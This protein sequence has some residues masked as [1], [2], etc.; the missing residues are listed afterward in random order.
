M[1]RIVLFGG[2][3][4]V[5]K[6]AV[7]ARLIPRL[8]ERGM[9]PCVC[10]IDCAACDDASVLAAGGVP[11]VTGVSVDTCPDH[12]LVSNLVE[13][14]MWAESR[15][16][17]TLLIETAGLCNRCSPATW[18]MLAGCVVD[19]TASC[20]APAHLGPMLSQADFAV[21][22]KVDMVS[23]AE[24][25][26]VCQAIADVNPRA[27]LFPVDGLAGYGI[28]ALVRY[29]AASS[30]TSDYE[31]D[32]LRHTMPAGVCSYCVGERRVGAAFQQG[33]VDKMDFGEEAA[34]AR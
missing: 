6:T 8:R 32:V 29:V 15:G 16:A 4:A 22:T 3:S 17:D 30:E 10:K 12:Y 24:R 18:R 1:R 33:V 26:I 11:V 5:G 23:Q 20:K 31:D 27:A 25:E 28:E 9:A 13:M 14:R 21:I 34:C 7:L 19:A 2:A